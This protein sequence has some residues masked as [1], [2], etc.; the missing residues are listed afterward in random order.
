L[1]QLVGLLLEE[2][3]LGKVLAFHQ[4]REDLVLEIL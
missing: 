2:L 4:E 3:I 1:F